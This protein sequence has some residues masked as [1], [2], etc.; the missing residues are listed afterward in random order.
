MRTPEDQIYAPELRRRAAED[1][2][3]DVTVIHTRS[4]PEGELRPV[5]R[6]SA[7]IL[8]RTAGLRR[9]TGLLRLRANRIR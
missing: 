8:S 3:L 2:G 6:I 7:M 9:W 5:G 4:A 1:G